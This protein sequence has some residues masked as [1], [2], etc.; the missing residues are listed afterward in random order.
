MNV[1]YIYSLF[2]KKTLGGIEQR[3]IGIRDQRLSLSVIERNQ[4]MPRNV[5]SYVDE[6]RQ[7]PKS[8][9]WCH[10]AQTLRK[11]CCLCSH[12][13]KTVLPHYNYFQG[14]CVSIPEVF[15]SL[16]LNRKNFSQTDYSKQ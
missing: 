5:N 10:A 8:C 9:R 3:L 16:V 14:Y 13:R 11:M 12:I 1:Q 7:P 2:V 15:W 6:R 4:S